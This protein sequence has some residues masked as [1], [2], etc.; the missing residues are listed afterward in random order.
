ML[1]IKV[2]YCEFLKEQLVRP[3]VPLHERLT[4]IKAV[5]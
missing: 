3:I 5:F 4:R 2:N 1:E